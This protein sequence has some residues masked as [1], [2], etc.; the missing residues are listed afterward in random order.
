MLLVLLC[1]FPL[2]HSSLSSDINKPFT[3]H[4]ANSLFL[5]SFVG[6]RC[7][8]F[9]CS[10]QLHLTVHL[11]QATFVLCFVSTSFQTPRSRTQVQTC[12]QRL[13]KLS[14]S[15]FTGY[16]LIFMSRPRVFSWDLT[17]IV[18]LFNRTLIS[19]LP[20]SFLV[21]G[22]F[23]SSKSFVAISSGPPLSSFSTH[24]PDQSFRSPIVSTVF[25]LH[26]LS[27]FTHSLYFN[28]GSCY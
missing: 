16:T 9:L 24:W 21:S 18:N 20:L 3:T 22:F 11:F 17:S 26:H 2:L 25:F 8:T 5:P 14:L 10:S 27:Q 7:H 4:V 15:I 28:S 6:P 23:T 12:T 19:P 13:R 1:L